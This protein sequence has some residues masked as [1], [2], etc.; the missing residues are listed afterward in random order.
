MTRPGWGRK[1]SPMRILF[2]GILL[3]PAALHAQQLGVPLS[4]LPG[5]EAGVASQVGSAVQGGIDG[6]AI[7]A[8]AINRLL[9]SPTGTMVNSAEIGA[10]IERSFFNG[11]TAGTPATA[12]SY[13]LSGGAAQAVAGQLPAAAS[14]GAVTA[15]GVAVQLPAAQQLMPANLIPGYQSLRGTGNASP[16]GVGNVFTGTGLPRSGDAP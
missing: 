16:T 3:A 12:S 9:G 7:P 15:S 1:L 10:Q 6:V 13:G 2:L 14:G 11:N 4:S 5:V 8:A